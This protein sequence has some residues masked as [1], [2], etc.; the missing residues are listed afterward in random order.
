MAY[1]QVALEGDLPKQQVILPRKTVL[2]LQRLLKD[3]KDESEDES[4]R[5]SFAPNQARFEFSNMEFVSKLIEGKF[6]D[7]NRVLPAS[8]S[9][10]VVLDRLILLASLQRAAILTAEKFKCVRLM[11]EP[12]L[13]KLDAVNDEQEEA[14]E[15]QEIDYSGAKVELGFNVSYLLDAFSGMTESSIEMGFQDAN[16]GVL[17]TI[18]NHTDFKYVV[19]P[20]RG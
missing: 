10:T 7:Y 9:N 4:I 13:M 11:L 19:M 2:E 12:G 14:T 20:M 3:N 6:P 16:A 1:A 18:P 5:L 8:Y 17:F 15:E